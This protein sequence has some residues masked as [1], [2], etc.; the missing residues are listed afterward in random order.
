MEARSPEWRGLPRQLLVRDED[1]SRRNGGRGIHARKSPTRLRY[2]TAS[3]ARRIPTPLYVLAERLF[4]FTRC[5]LLPGTTRQTTFNCLERGRDTGAIVDRHFAISPTT[6][7]KRVKPAVHRALTKNVNRSTVTAMRRKRVET[8][9][10][11][12][13]QLDP[14]VSVTIQ[15]FH[16]DSTRN[17]MNA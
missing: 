7:C 13:L 15:H 14:A 6:Q 9:R 16:V 2:V 3:S 17:P 11:R 10:L 5:K 4:R 1:S 8:G 12:L